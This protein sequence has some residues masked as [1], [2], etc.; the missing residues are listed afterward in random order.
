[1]QSAHSPWDEPILGGRA[2]R[3]GER[4]VGVAVAV[5]VVVVPAFIVH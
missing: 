5:A 3:E 1:M 2:D 4:G